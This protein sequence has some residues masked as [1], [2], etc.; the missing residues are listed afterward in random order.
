M[1]ALVL[2]GL[3]GTGQVAPASADEPTGTVRVTVTDAPGAPVAA[4]IVLLPVGGTWTEAYRASGVATEDFVVPPGRYAVTAV[5]PW[6]GLR[7]AGVAPCS[8]P[9]L[10]GDDTV[11]DDVVDVVAGGL[12]TYTLTAPPPA[13]VEPVSW[14]PG[15]LEVSFSGPM[16]QLALYLAGVAEFGHPEVQWLRD[17]AEIAGAAGPSYTPT[18]DDVGRRLSV[19]LSYHP[20]AADYLADRL[21]TDPSPVTVDGPVVGPVPSAVTARLRPASVPRG[22][23]SELVARVDGATGRVRVDVADWAGSCRLR[24]ARCRVR[25]PR[26][27]PGTHVV[28]VAYLGSAVLAPSTTFTVLTVTKE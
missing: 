14:D 22:H 21:G 10:S 9:D 8:L 12:A 11:V 24:D 4:A 27:R 1:V 20:F 2:A 13:E 16:E 28:D 17:G 26:L 19:R 25:L 18:V 23:R 3:L 5:T 7:C 15:R 6:G